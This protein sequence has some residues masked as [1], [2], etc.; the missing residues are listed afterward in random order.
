MA[1]QGEMEREGE[2]AQVGDTTG[3]WERRVE[4]EKNGMSG[5]SAVT[6]GMVQEGVGRSIVLGGRV[7]EGEGRGQ[8]QGNI[9]NDQHKMV[10]YVDSSLIFQYSLSV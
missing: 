2:K 6:G 1:I 9:G 7:V 5:G 3:R 4:M 8:V 10:R